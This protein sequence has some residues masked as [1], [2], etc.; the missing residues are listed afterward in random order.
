MMRQGMRDEDEA[1]LEADGACGG[2]PLDE[3]VPG[4]VNRGEHAGEGP[5]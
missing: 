4:I 1:P 2:D 3:D 5:R